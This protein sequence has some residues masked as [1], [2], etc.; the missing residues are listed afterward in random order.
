MDFYIIFKRL[1]LFDPRSGKHVAR[2]GKHESYG[3]RRLAVNKDLIGLTRS[4]IL[5]WQVL[6]YT[7]LAIAPLRSSEECPHI[8]VFTNT[9]A[10]LFEISGDFDVDFRL[11]DEKDGLLCGDEKVRRNDGVERHIVPANIEK[12]C[13]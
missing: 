8:C 5:K 6:R 12:P 4:D 13:N 7:N 9:D 11:V 2:R 10:L 1:C 3:V